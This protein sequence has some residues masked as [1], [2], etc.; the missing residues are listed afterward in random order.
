MASSLEAQRIVDAIDAE[1]L[2]K[3][4]LEL[5]KIDSTPNKE[6]LVAEFLCDWL[7]K[8]GFEARTLALVPERPNVY[9]TIRGTGD[10]YSLVFNAHMDIWLNEK[11]IWVVHKPDRAWFEAWI[12]GDRVYGQGVVNDKGPMAAFMIAAKALRKAGIALKGDLTLTMVP[13]EIGWEPVD[14]F[15]PPYYLSKEAGARYLITHGVVADFALVAE[16]SNFGLAWVEAGKAFFKV[17]VVGDSPTYTPYVT[18]DA[19]P[20]RHP[21]AVVKMTPVIRAI[22]QWAAEY[23]SKNRYE[24]ERGVLVP[25][26]S[27]GAIRGGVPYMILSSPQVCSVYVD[28]RLTPDGDPLAIRSELRKRIAS[29]GVAAEVELFLYRRGYEAQNVSRLVNAVDSA[30]L[31]VLG[32]PPKPVA[33]PICSMWRDNNV[34][35]EAGIPSLTYGPPAGFSPGGVGAAGTGHFFITKQDLAAAAK[36]YALTA[37]NLCNQPKL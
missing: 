23:E 16:V 35:N 27:I 32:S 15:Q 22:E 5:G 37:F 6:G 10:G 3:L 14:E 26:A 4:A 30:H 36:I 7:S 1:E 9:S 25:K 29:T 31:T 12:D 19:P 24:W 17:T 13:G 11:D 34:F 28:V 8:E 20:E 33:S 2:A 18:H 21:N